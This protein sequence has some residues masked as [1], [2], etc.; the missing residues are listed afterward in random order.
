METIDPALEFQNF[1]RLG[2]NIGMLAGAV[3][4]LVRLYRLPGI[5][6]ILPAKIQWKVLP[7]GV[8]YAVLLVLSGAGAA[9]GA[10]ATSASWADAGRAAVAALLAAITGDQLTNLGPVQAAA[11]VVFAISD[12]PVGSENTAAGEPT[13]APDIRLPPPTL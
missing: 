1:S 13:R 9:L 5:Q 6:Q 3:F 4:L 10:Y 8:R 2:G 12:K 11:K 7:L